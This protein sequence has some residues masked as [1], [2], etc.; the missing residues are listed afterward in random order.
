M[1]STRRLF[2]SAG[3]SGVL[4]LVLSGVEAEARPPQTYDDLT[5]LLQRYVDER[6]LV[7]YRAWK[8]KDE[9]ALREVVRRLSALDISGLAESPRELQAF[10]INV[11]NAVTLQ[12]MLEFFPLRS[13]RDKAVEGDAWN[14]WNDYAF[15]NGG[16]KYSL[17][18]IEHELLRP[19]GDPRIHAALNCASLGCPPLRREAFVAARLD[20]QLADQTRVWLND[21]NRG[22]RV[23]EGDVVALSEL[24]NWFGNDFA[25]DIPGRLRWISR[26]LRD[27][28]MREAITRRGAR[29]ESIPWDWRLNQQ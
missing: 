28:A 10:W 9:P 7:D 5:A 27:P 3:A 2:L 4:A 14:V 23:R 6:G 12:A 26:F 24:F 11:Y 17:N 22:V 21:P 15:E 8:E 16:R 13:I 20:E 25:P 18:Q 29:V 19:M 1:R